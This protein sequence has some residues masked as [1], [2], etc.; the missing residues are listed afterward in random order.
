MRNLDPLPP[1]GFDDRIARI[2]GDGLAVELEGGHR[3]T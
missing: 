2:E 1:C 3:F